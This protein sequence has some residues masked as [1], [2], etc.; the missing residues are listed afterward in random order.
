MLFSQNL[1]FRLSIVICFC[2]LSSC[3]A[4][5]QLPETVLITGGPFISGSDTAEREYAYQ[6]DADAYGSPTTRE[7]AWYSGEHTRQTLTTGRYE[8]MRTPVTNRQYAQFVSATGYAAPNVDLVTWNSY[9]LVHPFVTTRRFAW[10]DNL[11]PVGRADHPVVLVS[12]HDAIAYAHWL[13]D[14]SGLK[15]RLPTEQEWEKAVRGTDGRRFPWGDEFDSSLLNSHDAGPFDTL[16][17]GSYPAGASPYAVL[18]GAGQVFEWTSDLAG[19]DRAV[20]KGGSWDDRGCGVCRP[21]ARHSRP[22]HLKHV[23]I[24]FRLVREVKNPT[25]K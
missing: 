21:A 7:G 18:D 1:S 3:A 9:G 25:G 23:L 2:V 10:P 17:V 4:T 13:S 15:W 19:D 8:I 11:P 16:P 6:I 5:Q 14:F 20:V 22:R 24:G 12:Q